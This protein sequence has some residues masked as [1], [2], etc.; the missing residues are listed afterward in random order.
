[1]THE[2]VTTPFDW[3]EEQLEIRA[4]LRKR[5][6]SLE[7]PQ[8]ARKALE[9]ESQDDTSW[10]ELC[11]E[12]GLAGL[13]MPEEYGGLGFGRIEQSIV[14]EEMG[15]ALVGGPYLSTVVLAAQTIIAA[16]D[17]SA[18]EAFVPEIIEG[19]VKAALAVTEESHE[20]TV[21]QT[22]F[23][24]GVLTGTKRGVVGAIGAG[25]LVVSALDENEDESLYVVRVATAGD[26]LL[27]TSTPGIDAARMVATVE[28]RSTPAEPLG[29]NGAAQKVLAH[30]REGAAV[31]LA[32]DQAGGA[33]ACIELTAEYARTRIQFGQA[34]GRFQGVK[35]RLADMEVRVQQAHSAAVWASWQVPGTKAAALG[36]AVARIWCS[37]S[38]VQNAFDMIQLHGGIGITWEH[39]AHLYLRRAQS[40]AALLGPLA[41]ERA[42]LEDQLGQQVGA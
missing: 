13:T 39:D 8:V 16:E 32:A 15:R 11:S 29:R 27:L 41:Q 24:D 21:P 5:F 17:N 38:F 40:D 30:V 9:S 3:S 33:R 25:L 26:T 14:G 4:L 34:I 1:M 31:F 37:E 22:K 20:W 36:A 2:L 7:G 35:H 12:I 18:A 19:R 10:V 28:F 23:A 6:E 42:W